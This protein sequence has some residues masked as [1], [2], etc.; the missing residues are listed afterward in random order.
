MPL[1]WLSFMGDI[2]R[3]STYLK[4]INNAMAFLR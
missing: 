3:V 2:S 1:S 4:L